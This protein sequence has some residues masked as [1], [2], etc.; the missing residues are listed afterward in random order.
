MQDVNDAKEKI[1]LSIPDASLEDG[2]STVI[3]NALMRKIEDGIHI[4]CKSNEKDN[5]PDEWKSITHE[6]TNAVFPL[7]VI[8]D[9]VIWYGMPVSQGIFHDGDWNYKTVCPIYLRIIGQYT[10]DVIW[11]LTNLEYWT[12]SKGQKKQLPGVSTSSEKTANEQEI[13]GLPTYISQTE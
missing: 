2:S 1:V 13:P 7:I 5:L 8:D 10:I 12:D 3:Y 4:Y 11:P 9:K 6:T